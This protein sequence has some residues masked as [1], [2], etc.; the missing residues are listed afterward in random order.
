[1]EEKQTVKYIL[2]T[3]DNCTVRVAIGIQNNHMPIV[4]WMKRGDVY[5]CKLFQGCMSV[6]EGRQILAAAEANNYAAACR[7]FHKY[8]RG[9]LSEKIYVEAEGRWPISEEV[10][11]DWFDECKQILSLMTTNLRKVLVFE[12]EDDW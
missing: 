12:R 4:Y 1:M 7:L 5:S 9:V 11:D 2:L 10:P 3:I 6:E 8:F